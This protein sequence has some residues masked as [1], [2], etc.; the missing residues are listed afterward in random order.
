MVAQDCNRRNSSD[1]YLWE[2]E[3]PNNYG[4]MPSLNAVKVVH[5]MFSG[6][7]YLLASSA[8][9]NVGLVG[10]ALSPGRYQLREQARSVKSCAVTGYP[11]G[12]DGAILPARD[13]PSYPAR[14]TNPLLTK[15]VRS[16]WLDIGLILFLQVFGPRLVSVRKHAKKE[17]GQC[18]AILSLYLVNNPCMYT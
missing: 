18:P 5:F 8:A 4:E 1:V 2:A 3:Q 10:L 11:S 14:I 12:Q 16:R 13:Y 17:L 6:W 15:L 7:T 9:I